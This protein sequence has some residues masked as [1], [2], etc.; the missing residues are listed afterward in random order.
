[1]PG[2]IYSYSSNVDRA[3][4][5]SAIFRYLLAVGLGFY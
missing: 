2:C 3:G 5:F 4:L 1:M